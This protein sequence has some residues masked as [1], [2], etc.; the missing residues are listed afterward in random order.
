MTPRPNPSHVRLLG[1]LY[2]T[3]L[4]SC[5]RVIRASGTPL[6]VHAVWCVVRL[7]VGPVVSCLPHSALVSLTSLHSRYVRIFSSL[8]GPTCASPRGHTELKVPKHP[9]MPSTVPRNPPARSMLNTPARTR[10]HVHPRNRNRNRNQLTSERR[11]PSP[12]AF[13][14]RKVAHT[15]IFPEGGHTQL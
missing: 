9:E 6:R 7:L 10:T 12:P 13:R 8:A 2:Y 5:V 1:R 3:P 11:G 4:L 15:C 14:R